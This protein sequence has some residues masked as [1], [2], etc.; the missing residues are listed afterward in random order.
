MIG[1]LGRIYTGY[2]IDESGDQVFVHFGSWQ[3]R[4]VTILEIKSLDS[5]YLYSKRHITFDD[6]TGLT[7]QTDCYD[8]A[9][10]VVAKLGTGL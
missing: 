5:A 9:G 4:P 2:K 1:N 7:L 6:E 8:P 10:S 3:R